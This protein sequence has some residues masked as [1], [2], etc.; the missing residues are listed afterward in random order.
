[1]SY[2][3]LFE[4]LEDDLNLNLR[5]LTNNEIGIETRHLKKPEKTDLIGLINCFKRAYGFNISVLLFDNDLIIRHN[6]QGRVNN[7]NRINSSTIL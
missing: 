1:M 3:R 4:I 5:S 7:A 2:L 6:S